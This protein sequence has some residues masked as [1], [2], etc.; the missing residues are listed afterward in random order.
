[1]NSTLRI[2][3]QYSLGPGQFLRVPKFSRASRIFAKITV[4]IFSALSLPANLDPL[5]IFLS[6]SLA[7]ARL[8]MITAMLSPSRFSIRRSPIQAHAQ[9]RNEESVTRR[10][11]RAFFPFSNE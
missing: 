7:F 6:R 4:V 8:Y 9:K 3:N 1:M 10:R 5:Q 2:I 11:A